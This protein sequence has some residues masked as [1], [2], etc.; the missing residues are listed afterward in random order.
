MPNRPVYEL[1]T[2]DLLALLKLHVSSEASLAG[3]RIDEWFPPDFFHTVFWQLWR[4]TF[5]FQPWS[6]VAEMRRYAIRFMHLLPGFHRLEGIMR[7][8]YNQ[9]D[10]VVRPLETWLEQQGVRFLMEALVTDIDFELGRSTRPP[11]PSI[12]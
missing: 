2:E 9:Y 8:V 7:T 1:A 6:S 5:A 12:A 11:R 10:S 4:S 3:R